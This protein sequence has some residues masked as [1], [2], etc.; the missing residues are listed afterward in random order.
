MLFRGI[1]S[2]LLH[3]GYVSRMV[4]YSR[5]INKKEKSN[6]LKSEK[7]NTKD[8]MI[9]LLRSS[10][11]WLSNM[12]LVRLHSSARNLD[13]QLTLITLFARGSTPYPSSPPGPHTLSF[14]PS[15]HFTPILEF[16]MV[17]SI[18]RG[19]FIFLLGYFLT[20]DSSLVT[21]LPKRAANSYITR[22]AQQYTIL[23]SY[24]RL[25]ARRDLSA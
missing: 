18:P 23:V 12:K 24:K 4:F 22:A 15:R 1:N 17:S 16:A 13:F 8:C 3:C 19:V 5:N 2:S 10:H 21:C 11:R 14:P 9:I 6:L 20:M 25:A 7:S